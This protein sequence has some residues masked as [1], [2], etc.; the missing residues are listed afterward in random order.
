MHPA[1]RS[2]RLR[3]A[4]AATAIVVALVGNGCSLSTFDGLVFDDAPVPIVPDGGVSTPPSEPDTGIPRD[5]PDAHVLTW[6]HLGQ[7][8]AWPL[9]APPHCEGWAPPGLVTVHIGRLLETTGTVC[10]ADAASPESRPDLMIAGTGGSPEPIWTLDETCHV[11]VVIHRG[12]AVWVRY[13]LDAVYE[14][15][16]RARGTMIEEHSGGGTDCRALRAV[17]FEHSS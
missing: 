11:F 15:P 14:T 9:S 16:T 3:L 10:E 6:A 4:D 12:D 17:V 2:H 5:D 1:S 13:T 7:H 8:V